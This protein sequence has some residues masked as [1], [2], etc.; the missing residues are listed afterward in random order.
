VAALKFKT[1]ILESLKNATFV[2]KGFRCKS[3]DNLKSFCEANRLDP[4]RPEA[5]RFFRQTI[6]AFSNDL[7]K[8][9]NV[10]NE[11]HVQHKWI[12]DELHL[13]FR[14]LGPPLEC[15]MFIDDQ[16]LSTAETTPIGSSNTSVQ[17]RKALFLVGWDYPTFLRK[18]GF[19]PSPEASK[20]W[21]RLS[22]GASK[23]QIRQRLLGHRQM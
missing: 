19:P 16:Q 18:N 11:Q 15:E 22:R 7:E 23:L 20:M 5:K 10:L 6:M 8:W 14:Y 3:G 21:L 1:S 12:R 13:T 9:L 17:E 2:F 4:D